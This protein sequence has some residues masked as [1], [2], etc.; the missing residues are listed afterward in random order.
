MPTLVQACTMVIRSHTENCRF[1]QTFYR[2][3]PVLP[4]INFP[5]KIYEAAVLLRFA[6]EI[7]GGCNRCATTRVGLL[8][9]FIYC[10]ILIPLR[11]FQNLGVFGIVQYNEKYLTISY[12]ISRV[13]GIVMLGNYSQYRQL[14]RK[15]FSILGFLR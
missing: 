10:T 8:N 7:E 1:F 14:Y 2:N 13:Y 15:Q 6:L 3:L 4:T 12:N 9:L 5:S 11:F